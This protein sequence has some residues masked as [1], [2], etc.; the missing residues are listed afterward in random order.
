MSLVDITIDDPKTLI[1]IGDHFILSDRHHLLCVGVMLDWARWAPL[2]KEGVIFCP[3]PGPFTPFGE[4]P[5]KHP[6][7]MVQPD[8]YIAGHIVD[9]WLSVHGEASVK[10]V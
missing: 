1:Q 6:L 8:K 3:Y 2:L 7:V 4:K 10:K 9:H 5:K